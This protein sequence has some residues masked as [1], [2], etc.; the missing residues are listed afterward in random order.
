MERKVDLLL[1]ESLINAIGYTQP[2]KSIY[3]VS[4]I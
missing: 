2:H 3:E 4:Q 1:P